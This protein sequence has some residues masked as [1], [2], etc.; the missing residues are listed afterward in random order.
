MLG[1]RASPQGTRGPLLYLLAPQGWTLCLA[2]HL[3]ACFSHSRVSNSLSLSVPAL[4]SFTVVAGPPHT[5][6]VMAAG[7]GK[8]DRSLKEMLTKLLGVQS[9]DTTS[10]LSSDAAAAV[11]GTNTLVTRPF[12]E[13]LFASLRQSLQTLKKDLSVDRR[14]VRCDLDSLSDRISSLKDYEMSHEKEIEQLQ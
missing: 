9:S 14:E 8:K 11:G 12:L 7:W 2:E 1:S 6:D 13:P 5:T 4:P 10:L 3:T